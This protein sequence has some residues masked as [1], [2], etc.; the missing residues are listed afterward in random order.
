M[1]IERA[2]TFRNN[3]ASRVQSIYTLAPH[4]TP[5]SSDIDE[6]MRTSVYRYLNNAK[7]PN[8]ARTYVEGYARAL[9]DA[10]YRDHLIFGGWIGDTFYSAHRNRPDYYQTC[11]IEPAEYADDG[12]VKRRGHYWA[13][14]LAP[15]FVNEDEASA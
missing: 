14:N 8:W 1:R 13:H 5:T 9:G 7:A 3:A 4:H 10:L 15:F 11:G 6:S 2:L 12:K